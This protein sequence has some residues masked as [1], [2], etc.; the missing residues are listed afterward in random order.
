MKTPVI[1]A[2]GSVLSKS[3]VNIVINLIEKKLNL[4][5]SFKPLKSLGDIDLVSK[6][7]DITKEG[8]FTSTIEQALL[9]KEIDIAVHSFKDLP[10]VNSNK[11][12]ICAVLPRNSP[13]DLLIIYKESLRYDE[14]GS[15][16]ITNG[17]R[18]ATG[19]ERRR[20]QLLNEFPNVTTPDIRG[21]VNTRIKKLLSG[22]Y[23]G[24]IMAEAVFERIQIEIPENIIKIPL[25][26]E[27][28]PTS[29]AQGA[30]CLQMEEDHALL[31]IVSTL[32]D[33]LTEK[34]VNLEREIL[35]SLGG[36]CQLPLGVTI[37]KSEGMWKVSLSIAH[38]DW[39]LHKQP[40][41]TRIFLE[42]VDF[43]SIKEKILN[44]INYISIPDKNLD[45][46][47]ILLV[48]SKTTTD[49]YSFP[50]M[51]MGANVQSLNFFDYSEI[52][53]KEFIKNHKSEW[54]KADWI[55]IS[56]KRAIPA[57]ISFQKIFPKKNVQ[58]ATIGGN[59]A[60]ILQSKGLSV[61]IISK[62]GTAKSLI[63]DMKKIVK[64]EQSLLILGAKNLIKDLTSEL[65]KIENEFFSI[66]VYEAIPINS[67]DGITL[68]EEYDYTIFFSSNHV[69]T[70]FDKFSNVSSKNWVAIGPTTAKTLTDS[71]ISNPKTATQRSLN[72]ILEVIT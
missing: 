28:Y 3:Q 69:K 37:I 9:K 29:P 43:K 34:A 66:P 35:A 23:D 13:K 58:V 41:L 6:I 68:K 47:S 48:G 7:S 8:S 32:N 22:I 2:R 67:F 44:N 14:N 54:E 27:K 45:K 60:R 1:G 26:L 53:S 4:K 20:S 49:S 17:S 51:T 38:S 24:I 39:K 56:S 25:P 57:L 42:T 55:I 61:H 18:I 21:N 63:S 46:K 65:T 40:N 12:R 71:G 11:L 30:I 15:W 72:G 31:D 19:S 62:E 33:P 36:G 52:W 10:T 64:K 50:I 70:F 59:T 5:V 16:K